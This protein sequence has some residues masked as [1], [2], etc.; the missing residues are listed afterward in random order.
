VIVELAHGDAVG[1]GRHSGLVNSVLPKTVDPDPPWT[2]DARPPV[3][4]TR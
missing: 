2:P 1:P 3:T 4:G